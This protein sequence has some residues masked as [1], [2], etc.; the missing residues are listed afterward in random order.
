MTGLE[1]MSKL[2]LIPLTTLLRSCYPST[3]YNVSPIAYQLQ[4]QASYQTWSIQSPP[5]L[6]QLL[7]AP[8]FTAPAMPCWHTYHGIRWFLFRVISAPCRWLR[9]F[10]SEYVMIESIIAITFFFIH[11]IYQWKLP[12]NISYTVYYVII[13]TLSL[14]IN[15]ITATAK[16]WEGDTTAYKRLPVLASHLCKECS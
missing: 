6:W 8:C 14:Y 16:A 10:D 7:L 2:T 9:L 3:T 15:I 5:K 11:L 1:L 4:T 13:K 12:T